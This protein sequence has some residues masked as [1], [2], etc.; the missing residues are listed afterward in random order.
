MS[1]ETESIKSRWAKTVNKYRQ[2][3]GIT[4]ND[5]K[6]MNKKDLKTRIREW[7]TRRWRNDMEGK[8]TLKWYKDGKKNIQYDQCYTNSMNSKILARART[9][10]LQVEE[11]VHRRNREHNTICRLCGLEEEDL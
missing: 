10:T 2:E 4:W 9:N 8:P 3:I 5:M 7:D 6:E 1:H 11:F